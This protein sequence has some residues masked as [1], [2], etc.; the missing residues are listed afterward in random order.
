M[1]YSVFATLLCLSWDSGE[2]KRHPRF[3]RWTMLVC[4]LLGTAYT[5]LIVQQSMDAAV[6]QNR[7]YG[8]LANGDVHWNALPILSGLI[9]SIV[10]AYLGV[11]AGILITRRW[12]RYAF[13]IWL[14]CL[15]LVGLAF[16]S[17]TCVDGVLFYKGYAATDLPVTYNHATA[18][19]LF[20]SAGA[21][22]SI[23]IACAW[24]LR[25]RMKG[26]NNVTDGLLR[27]L[28]YFSVRTA[29]ISCFF[30]IVSSVVLLS[31]G[32]TDLESFLAFAFWMPMPGF[33][34]LSLFTF[35]ASSRRAIDERLGTNTTAAGANAGTPHHQ[36]RGVY[37]RRQVDVVSG[38]KTASASSGFPPGTG[39]GVGTSSGGSA[40]L[41]MPLQISVHQQS[42]TEYD[43]PAGPVDM[44]GGESSVD[45]DDE[46]EKR[47]KREEGLGA[48]V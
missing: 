27:R 22:L 38:R 33:Y 9:G 35:Q 23:T 5:A 20:T 39:Q 24:A 17:L 36:G 45:E 41:G 15:I 30:S 1:L 4:L 14:A 18:V 19:W 26:F 10:E 28:I 47:D 32:D 6:D 2:F 21:D 34:C 12:L 31:L 48:F 8:N 11:R 16:A 43:E 40:R 42:V 13:W 7:T 44:G 25:S 29:A 3:G 46:R 37:I